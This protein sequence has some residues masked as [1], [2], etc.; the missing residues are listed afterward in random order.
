VGVTA[1]AGGGSTFSA[2]CPVGVMAP[3][4]SVTVAPDATELIEL[5]MSSDRG[6]RLRAQLAEKHHERTLDDIDDAIQTACRC[7]ID[8]RPTGVDAVATLYAWLRTVADRVLHRERER[9]ERQVPVNPA[10][11]K[12][13]GVLSDAPSP[14]EQ[15]IKGEDRHD[16]TALVA[17]VASRLHDDRQRDVLALYGAHFKRP[18][19][20]EHLGVRLR[21]V[22]RD[23][24]E[25]FEQVRAV[26]AQQAGGGCEI[27]E[28][29][30]IRVVC[31]MATDVEAA[32]AEM[33]M[34]RCECCRQFRER[35]DLWREKVAAVLPIPAVAQ[36]QPGLIERTLHKSVDGF[37]WV[38]Q[39]LTDGGTQVKQ[40]VATTYSMRVADPTP[41]AGAR[42]GAVAAVVAGCVAASVAAYTCV[43][44][45]IEAVKGK[46]QPADRADAKPKRARAAQVQP[47]APPPPQAVEVEPAP[48]P[49]PV[50]EPPPPP[51]PPPYRRDTGFTPSSPVGE[52][53]P[54]TSRQPTTPEPVVDGTSSEFQP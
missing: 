49:A 42:P 10:S 20:A 23:L 14:E 25:I 26:L 38:R 27:G 46:D 52:S 45:T 43:D 12:L 51:P 2:R 37:N 1:P 16:L 53:E 48:Q 21:V 44:K 7:Y 19:I 34:D 30:V 29:L 39:Y 11:P 36:I 32:H 15:A 40:Q 5:V 18:E 9:L 33:H 28:P 50:V 3:S 13:T 47:V 41:L 22:R 8:E 6:A 24:L 17:E 31:G 4:N 54:K 35:L